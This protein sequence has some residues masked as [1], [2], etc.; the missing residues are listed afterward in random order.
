[1]LVPINSD[2]LLAVKPAPLFNRR[3]FFAHCVC[4]NTALLK[5]AFDPEAHR[6]AII[7]ASTSPMPAVPSQPLEYQLSQSLLSSE[8][9]VPGPFNIQ[10]PP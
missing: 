5:G 2:M 3:K 9:R 10:S 4:K 6:P 8:T 7:P 1:M